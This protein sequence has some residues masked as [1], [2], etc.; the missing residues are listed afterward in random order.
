MYEK[1]LFHN[2][3]LIEIEI[4]FYDYVIFYQIYIMR[5]IYFFFVFL[6]R[7]FSKICYISFF[8]CGCYVILTFYWPFDSAC[9]LL[10]SCWPLAFDL[11]SRRL[12]T[13]RV[14]QFHGEGREKKPWK[15]ENC[16]FFF[17]LILKEN[18]SI[19]RCPGEMT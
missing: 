9:I 2:P 4:Y 8:S 13:P 12:L 18:K 15:S 7:F 10:S 5:Y 1:V 19:F 17:F 6:K 3:L 11:I 14:W 16:F